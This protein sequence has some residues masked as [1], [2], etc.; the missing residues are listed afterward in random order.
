[1]QTFT[2][3]FFAKLIYRFGNIFATIF[4]VL[5][6]TPLVLGADENLYLLIPLIISLWLLYYIN[7][8]YLTLYKVMPYKIEADDE[9]IICTD[10]IFSDKKVI[11]YYKD[12][13]HLSGGIFDAKIR[14]IMKACDGKNKLC[15]GFSEK[16]KE[17]QTLITLILSKVK[18][19]IYNE[20]IERLQALKKTKKK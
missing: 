11:I 15:I 5:Y 20:V 4:L 7:K 9:K 14:G 10:F 8:K 16:M 12:I 17:S 18:K 19:E 3:P 13:D 2:Y 6:Q 1:M